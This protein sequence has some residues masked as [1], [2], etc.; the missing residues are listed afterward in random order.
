MTRI[1][2]GIPV[3]DLS[4]QHLLAEHRELKRIP[5]AVRKGRFSMVGQPK[6][7]KLG[8]GHVKFFYDKLSYL[9]ERY[10]QLYAEC[11][12]RKYD[13]TYYG[14]SFLG[15]DKKY[16]NNYQPTENDIKLIKERIDERTKK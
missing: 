3:V 9:Q 11:I 16:F 6:Q 4:R 7:F 13:V 12:R 10:E 2:I 14:N 8:P 5:N 15:I 1:N